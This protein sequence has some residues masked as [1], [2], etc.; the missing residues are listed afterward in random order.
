MGSKPDLIAGVGDPLM[1]RTI[2]TKKSSTLPFFVRQLEN[3]ISEAEKSV[4]FKTNLLKWAIKADNLT[5]A[6]SQAQFII[7]KSSEIEMLKNVHQRITNWEENSKGV[8]Q[9]QCEDGVITLLKRG[10]HLIEDVPSSALYAEFKQLAECLGDDADESFDIFQLKTIGK[11]EKMCLIRKFIM[12]MCMETPLPEGMQQIAFGESSARSSSGA[13]TVGKSPDVGDYSSLPSKYQDSAFSN[14]DMNEV[15]PSGENLIIQKEV[16]VVPEVPL[17]QLV[18]NEIPDSNERP[19]L[20]AS[21]AK[22]TS[23]YSSQFQSLWFRNDT[24]KTLGEERDNLKIAATSVE[25]FRGNFARGNNDLRSSTGGHHYNE[26]QQGLLTS[27]HVPLDS[28]EIITKEETRVE[29]EGNHV[30]SSSS[31]DREKAPYPWTTDSNGESAFR[32]SAPII[33]WYQQRL[34]QGNLWCQRSS[35]A[36][37]PGRT[38]VGGSLSRSNTNRQSLR[39]F[40]FNGNAE[41]NVGSKKTKEE[42]APVTPLMVPPS[43]DERSISRNSSLSSISPFRPYDDNVF[44]GTPRSHSPAAKLHRSRST[45]ET[46][47]VAVIGVRERVIELQHRSA[48]ASPSA[49]TK[50]HF[51]PLSLIPQLRQR[52]SELTVDWLERLEGQLKQYM[53]SSCHEY[54]VILRWILSCGSRQEDSYAAT[55][56]QTSV[57]DLVSHLTARDAING[58]RDVLPPQPLRGDDYFNPNEMHSHRTSSGRH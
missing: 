46:S 33:P 32:G 19:Q 53:E 11:D 20:V 58:S 50:Q 9:R 56:L 51:P 36:E 28:E 29:S 48:T 38:S 26:F 40:L 45:S 52:K 2:C 34:N 27:P 39:S 23:Y 22:T 41:Q 8:S 16:P 13:R 30:S 4:S 31:S 7:L 44:N 43:G 5:M 14:K 42:V 49:A 18:S 35:E 57:E 15:S 24:S 3:A 17:T 55:S 21:T 47:D 6:L 37:E 12:E 54:N 10:L 25:G 1:Y